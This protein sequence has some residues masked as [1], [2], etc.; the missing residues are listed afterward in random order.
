MA[1]KPHAVCLHCGYYKGKEVKHIETPEERQAKK[2]KKT[3]RQ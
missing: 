2:D 1:K 3:K